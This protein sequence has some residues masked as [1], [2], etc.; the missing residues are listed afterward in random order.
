MVSRPTPFPET[1][2]GA[3]GLV[4]PRLGV[5]DAGPLHDL[6]MAHK[7]TLM[8][9]MEWPR[10]IERL[11]DTLAFTRVC[12][13][14]FVA[15][16]LAAYGIRVD[17]QLVGVVSFNEFDH[18]AGT[19]YVGYWLAPPAQGRGW[20]TLAV[21]ALVEAYRRAELLH[22]FVIKCSTGNERSRL[23]AQRLGFVWEGTLPAAER[24]GN[25]MHDHHIYSRSF[26]VPRQEPN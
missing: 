21:Q 10:A 18:G 9:W 1:L 13:S 16:S 5:A 4:A 8:Q 12:E 2:D 22:R 24:I 20:A 7:P 25:V 3:R 14:G 17:G 15:R 6:V 19:G 23:L 11:D 26:P